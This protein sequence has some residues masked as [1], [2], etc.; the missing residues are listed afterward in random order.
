MDSILAHVDTVDAGMGK[1]VLG[2][3]SA[4]QLNVVIARDGDEENLEGLR[5][6][7]GENIDVATGGFSNI[8]TRIGTGNIENKW[9]SCDVDG[10]M[11]VW[12]IHANFELEDFFTFLDEFVVGFFKEVEI[13]L[14]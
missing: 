7:D 13:A 10:L 6:D 4:V 14:I 3:S 12:G 11:V 1:L 2:A 5:V 9:F 8:A